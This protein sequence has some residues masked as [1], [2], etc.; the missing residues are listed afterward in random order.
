MSY[1]DQK[2]LV[3]LG[4]PLYTLLVT[5]SSD[6][7]DICLKKTYLLEAAEMVSQPMQ[8]WVWFHVFNNSYSHAESRHTH[9]QV[10]CPLSWNRPH[11]PGNTCVCKYEFARAFDYYGY[12]P[13]TFQ[14]LPHGH[15]KGP[16]ITIAVPRDCY[17][18]CPG[19]CSCRKG[20]SCG[21]FMH[22]YHA[23]E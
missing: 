21:F 17:S 2:C 23:V 20:E 14:L 5:R 10:I 15:C 19:M 12:T 16:N 9:I 8:M 11:I 3:I 22:G 6:V 4:I 7:S 18:L 1:N 13:P